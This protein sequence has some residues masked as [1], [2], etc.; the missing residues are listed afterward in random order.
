VAKNRDNEPKFRLRPRKPP[1]QGERRVYTSAYRIIMHH[2]RMSGVR[3]RRVIG[4]GT[5]RT[6]PRPYSQRCAVRVLHSKNTSNGQW[7]AHGRYVARESATHGGDPRAVGFN[8]SEES[9]DIAARLEGWQKA[10]DER[11]WK[12]IVSPEFGD[13]L[14]L[15]RLT[16]DLISKMETDLG[17]RLEWVAAAHFNTEHPHIHI[18]LRGAGAEGRP[19][20]LSRDFIT[21]GIRHITEELC[22]RQLGYR[23]EFDA[24]D[25]QRREVH[26]HR[27]TSLDRIIQ[28]DA[29]RAEAAQSPFFTVSKDPSRAGLGPSASL[30]ERRSAERLMVLESIGLAESSGPK[31]W[32]VRRDFVDIL[33]AMQRRADHQKTLAAHGALISDARLQM[34][35]LDL[36]SLTTLEGRIL[37]HGEVESSGRSY[38]ILEGTDA[39]VHYVYYTPEIEA[40]RSRGGLRTNSFIQLRKSTPGNGPALEIDDVGDSEAMLR[41]NGKLRQLGQRLLRRGIIPQDDG[42]GGWLGR[43]QK[44]LRDAVT[45]LEIP[46]V[47]KQSERRKSRDL[48]R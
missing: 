31:T 12:L 17:T 16:R 29:D 24:A 40:A 9:I 2:A 1:A 47:T 43:Y 30:I 10:N 8:T 37:V 32:R 20:R 38:L 23:S 42:W 26:Q 25:A 18:A 13:R 36:R 22:T 34:T 3:R 6:H 5:G 39:R 11:L 48:G 41:N 33:R 28:R 14:D 44:A 35:V 21:E 7:R 19:L 4:F 45:I 15:K 46:S 27:C